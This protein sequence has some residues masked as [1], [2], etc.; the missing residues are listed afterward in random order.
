MPKNYIIDIDP[1]TGD[2]LVISSKGGPSLG[3]FMH[4]IEGDH[5]TALERARIFIYALEAADA[6]VDMTAWWNTTQTKRG[7]T[8][9]YPLEKFGGVYALPT[10]QMI[11][12][13]DKS[14]D[15]S[16]F[17]MIANRLLAL[18]NDSFI[19]ATVHTLKP[20]LEGGE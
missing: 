1:A 10:L 2:P 18:R 16:G 12:I 19:A 15:Q 3:Q 5:Y 20:F 6:Q 8:T 7:V 11:C 9:G 17:D 13:V 14:S 4:H